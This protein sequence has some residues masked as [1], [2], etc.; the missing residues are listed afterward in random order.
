MKKLLIQLNCIDRKKM[1]SINE[2]K[3]R[4]DQEIKDLRQK[5]IKVTKDLKDTKDK[6][7]KNEK[8]KSSLKDNAFLRK[9]KSSKNIGMTSESEEVTF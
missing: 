8:K 7:E 3:T 2:M 4:K 1:L 6:F 9:V 5:F